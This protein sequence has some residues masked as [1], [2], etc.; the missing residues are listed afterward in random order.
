MIPVALTL[1]TP[2]VRHHCLRLSHSLFLC[3]I[4]RRIVF[5]CSL[6]KNVVEIASS[7]SSLEVGIVTVFIKQN[8]NLCKR[9]IR[10]LHCS[11]PVKTLFADRLP[12]ATAK[13]CMSIELQAENYIFA[14]VT[15]V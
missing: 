1:S 5:V 15:V 9:I 10:F 7:D 12:V 4:S 8:L 6:N 11:V 14:C 13:R 2:A 3:E